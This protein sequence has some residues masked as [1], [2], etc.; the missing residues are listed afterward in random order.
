MMWTRRYTL[1]VAGPVT[2]VPGQ[3]WT[4]ILTGRHY[5]LHG[6]LPRRPA[7]MADQAVTLARARSG[8]EGTR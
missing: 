7:P 3:K 2:I 4:M 1:R 6:H 5:P 8:L